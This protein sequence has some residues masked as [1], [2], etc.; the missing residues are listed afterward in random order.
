MPDSAVLLRKRALVLLG[1]GAVL[2]AATGWLCY[3]VITS[4]QAEA[5]AARRPAEARTILAAT[6]NLAAGQVVSPRDLRT[7]TVAYD[8]AQADSWFTDPKD[9]NG[10]VLG[11]P[12]LAGEPLRKE[13]FGDAATD[14]A[15]SMQIAPGRRAVTV[16]LTRAASVGG[17]LRRGDLVDVM[18]T[19]RPEAT[20]GAPS[21]VTETILQG[22][23]VLDIG[24][25][26]PEGVAALDASTAPPRDAWLTLQLI[27]SEAE[28][29]AMA[30]A[31]GT[32]HCALRA[33]ADASVE[34]GDGPLQTR[35][36][37]GMGEPARAPKSS[38]AHGD[39]EAVSEVIQG[40]ATTRARFRAGVLL[41]ATGGSNE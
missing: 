3:R 1:T 19:I 6:R 39:P 17:E 41:P 26:R 31:R 40:S 36:L 15:L 27:P 18:V 37:V 28:K 33:R 25:H 20:T 14:L 5:V 12:V 2:A 32:I 29:L 34:P 16:E 35:T 10:L 30:S 9:V 7:V 11:S 22:A 23:E 21:W 4:Y 13:R 38:A 24:P 8:A